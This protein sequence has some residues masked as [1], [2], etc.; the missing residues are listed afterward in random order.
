[1]NEP[2]YRSDDMQHENSISHLSGWRQAGWLALLVAAS[3]AF[4]LGFACAMPFAAFGA[5]AALTLPRRDALLVTGAAWLANQIIGFAVL[6]YPGTANTIAWGAVL[7]IVAV[8]TTL[9]AQGVVG[10]FGHRGVVAVLG[11]FLGAFAIYE[12]ALF[13]VSATLLGGTEDYQLSI[14]IRILEINAAA[15]IGLL[16]LSR[17]GVVAGLANGPALRHLAT[18]RH[19]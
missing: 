3:V 2:R 1:M 8:L 4:T 6:G 13:L 15:L 12:G 9:T 16:V 17:L 14:V 11:S 7:G 10:R 18:E 19:A 5:A